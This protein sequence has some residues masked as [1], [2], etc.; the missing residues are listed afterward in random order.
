M[1]LIMAAGHAILSLPGPGALLLGVMLAG[2][3]YGSSYPLTLFLVVEL[4]G[5]E[6]VASNYMIFDG[7]PGAI[8]T[9][10]SAK[11]LAGAI[12]HHHA[13]PDGKCRGDLPPPCRPG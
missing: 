10:L 7:T 2:F 8:G 11:M 9:F 13:D 4:F 3:A 5:P 1:M 6:R 12:Y